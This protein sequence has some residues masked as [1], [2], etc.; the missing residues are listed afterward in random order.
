MKKIDK[1][2]KFAKAYKNWIEDTKTFSKYSG[3]KFKNDIL[4]ELLIAQKG[5]CAYTE[6][7]FDLSEKDIAEIKE[8]FDKNGKFSGNTP[9]VSAELDHFYPKKNNEIKLY[10]WDNFFAVWTPINQKCK[11]ANEPD[12]ILKPDSKNYEVEKYLD[13]NKKEHKFV[14]NYK[15]NDDEFEKVNYMINDVLCM[16]WGE[17]VR[18]RKKYIS[19]TIEKWKTNNNTEITQFPTAFEMYKQKLKIKK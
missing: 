1:N 6:Y 18:K 8:Q 3:Q 11:K 12:T 16:N 13:Y 2:I 17:I 10:D 14:P 19:E 7:S 4:A 15:L 5:L 9:D